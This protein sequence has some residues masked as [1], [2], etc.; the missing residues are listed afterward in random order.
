MHVGHWMFCKCSSLSLPKVQP[1]AE[2]YRAHLKEAFGRADIPVHFA[3]G[4]VRPDPAGRAFFALLECAAEGLSARNEYL[5]LGQVP[6]AAPAGVAPEA[7][8]RGDLWVTP[9]PEVVPTVA[10]ENANDYTAPPVANAAGPA[11][12]TTKGATPLGAPSR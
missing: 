11:R 1:S 7:R 9:D 3:P 6:D 8:S 2:G 10:P 4:A 12:R 5:S